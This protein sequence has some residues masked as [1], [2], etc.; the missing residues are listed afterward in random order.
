[1]VANEATSLLSDIVTEASPVAPIPTTPVKSTVSRSKLSCTL[2]VSILGTETFKFSIDSLSSTVKDASITASVSSES[3]G[4]KSTVRSSR[5]LLFVIAT[6]SVSAPV[7]VTVVR[8]ELLFI[9]IP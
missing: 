3:A 1:M 7:I 4:V 5:S 9:T 8:S 2:R 6:S